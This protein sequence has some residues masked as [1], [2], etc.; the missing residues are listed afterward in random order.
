VLVAGAVVAVGAI[1]GIVLATGGSSSNGPSTPSRTPLGAPAS[2]G[3]FQLQPGSGTDLSADFSSGRYQR[4]GSVAQQ[5]H[6]SVI[7]VLGPQV[8]PSAFDQ[9]VSLARSD[10]AAGVTTQQVTSAGVDYTCLEGTGSGASPPPLEACLWA[11]GPL[12]FTLEAAGSG[13]DQQFVVNLAPL[14]QSG[15]TS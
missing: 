8:S 2:I 12:V 5:L 14:A 6:F 4:P 7:R 3:P 1:V 9:E 13:V 10:F 11:S 15:T